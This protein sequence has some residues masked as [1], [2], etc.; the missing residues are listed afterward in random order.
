MRKVI[1]VSSSSSDKK[2]LAP[3]APERLWPLPEKAA[4]FDFDGTVSDTASLW[5]EVDRAFLAKRAIPYTTIHASSRPWGSMRG[6]ATR[7]SATTSTRIRTISWRN[8]C[9]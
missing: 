1:T 3:A 8:G 9:T 6:H 2:A 5:E 4:I 7:S